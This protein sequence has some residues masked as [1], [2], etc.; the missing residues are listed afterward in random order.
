M[1]PKNPVDKVGLHI[2]KQ[3]QEAEQAKKTSQTAMLIFVITLVIIVLMAIV[4]FCYR[5]NNKSANDISIYDDNEQQQQ[6]KFMGKDSHADLPIGPGECGIN[7]DDSES[8]IDNSSD[9][10]QSKMWD[11]DPALK[12]INRDDSYDSSNKYG[13]YDWMGISN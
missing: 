8:S 11:E 1:G 12:R 13:K 7:A 3:K 9:L 5:F 6:R 10:T 4:F 2:I